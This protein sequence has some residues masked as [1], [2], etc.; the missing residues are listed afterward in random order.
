MA[1]INR[2]LPFSHIF[3]GKDGIGGGV[4]DQLTGFTAN[5]TPTHHPAR[6]I[7]AAQKREIAEMRDWLKQNK[8]SQRM[9]AG[10]AGLMSWNSWPFPQ[11]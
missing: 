3:V 7:I 6:E 10:S 8:I 11:Q 4:V 9:R 2:R 5:S 1:S